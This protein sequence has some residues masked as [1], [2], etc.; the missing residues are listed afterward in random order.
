MRGGGGGGE[1]SGIVCM[2]VG[3][4][5]QLRWGNPC[6]PNQ[7]T[8]RAQVTKVLDWAMAERNAWNPSEVALATAAATVEFVSSAGG[9]ARDSNRLT[10]SAVKSWH[11]GVDRG[12]W[13]GGR[14]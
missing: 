8:W 9:G 2:C 4:V 5:R 6:P 1:W 10:K 7:H 12:V 3:G 13:V 14:W 11:T